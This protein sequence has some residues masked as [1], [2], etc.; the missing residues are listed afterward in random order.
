MTLDAQAAGAV[1]RDAPRV[2]RKDGIAEI[3]DAWRLVRYQDVVRDA[4]GVRAQISG[5]GPGAGSPPVSQ[6]PRRWLGLP[7]GPEGRPVTSAAGGASA[8]YGTARPG[9]FSFG[10][11]CGPWSPEA[12][13]PSCAL[14]V[15]DLALERVCARN[16]SEAPA[17]ARVV[18]SSPTA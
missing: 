14:L 16:A 6:V 12:A 7:P 13:A 3:S 9:G 4:T 2:R 1:L 8:A 18:E 15:E 10:A 5:R 11:A 17:E